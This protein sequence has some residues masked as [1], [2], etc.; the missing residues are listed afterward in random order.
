M[1]GMHKQ[2]SQRGMTIVEALVVCGV[3]A[4]LAS[5]A[6]LLVSRFW[7]SRSINDIARDISS[8]IQTAKLRSARDGLEYRLV[9]ASCI[10]VDDTD[11]DCR[12]CDGD[13]TDFVAGDDTLPIS[14]ERGNSNTGSTK[15]CIESSHKKKM[16]GTFDLD[17]SDM[18]VLP[19]TD[20]YRIVFSPK[21][22]LVDDTDGSPLTDDGDTVSMLVK[23]TSTSRVDSC[24]CVELSLSLG[25]MSVFRGHWDGAQCCN[26]I[27]DGSPDALECCLD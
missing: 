5:I 24:G 8:T 20:P 13:Y 2:K 26:P 14:L 10:N 16:A 3:L 17:L 6:G 27:R 18:P 22:F 4:I 12:F 23:P 15:W 11:P 9:L 7:Q 21:G 19:G 25:R 1:S